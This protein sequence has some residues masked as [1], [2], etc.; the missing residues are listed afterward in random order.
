MNVDYLLEIGSGTGQHAAYFSQQLPHLQWQPTDREESLAA[1]R[2]WLDWGSNDNLLAP[3]ELDVNKPWP[4]NATPFIFSANTLHIMS[5]QEVENFFSAVEK[6][7]SE[8][9]VLAIYGPFNYDGNFTSESNANFEQ[10]LKNRNSKSGIRDFEAVNN[11]AE[12]AGL[13]LLEDCTMPANNRFLVWNK[14]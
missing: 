12:Q 14:L 9:G 8:S 5:W 6:V 4:V 3:L 10:W 7:L 13:T 11:L 1:V 2:S